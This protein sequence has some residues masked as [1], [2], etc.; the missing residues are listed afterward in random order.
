M[1]KNIQ[2][3]IEIK[4][5]VTGTEAIKQLAATIG[6]AGVDTAKLSEESQ[7]LAQ[8]W[9][10]IENRHSLINQYKALK[11]GLKEVNTEMTHTRQPMTQLQAQMADGAASGTTPRQPALWCR[12]WMT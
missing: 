11:A 4:A 2:T 5:G 10:D 9:A 1:A 3:G 6:E 7:A 12:G 8:A